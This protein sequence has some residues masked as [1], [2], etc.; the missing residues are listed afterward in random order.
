MNEA[1]AS[2]ENPLVTVC[3]LLNRHGAAYLVAGG[4]AVILHGH[5]RTTEDVDLMIEPTEENARRVLVARCPN[6]PTG[7]HAS[8]SP[9]SCWTTSSSRS[10]TP[11]RWT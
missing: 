4:Q 11:S 2:A 1:A 9:A 6:C 5:V 7:P 10:P 8:S 3:R